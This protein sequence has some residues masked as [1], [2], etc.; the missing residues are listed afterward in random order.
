M[1]KG[2]IKRIVEE[3][4]IS[5]A[6]EQL[7]AILSKLEMNENQLVNIL[8]KESTRRIEIDKRRRENFL[9]GRRTLKEEAEYWSLKAGIVGSQNIIFSEEDKER[10][11][12][13]ETIIRV[14]DHIHASPMDAVFKRKI[15]K[16]EKD[17]FKLFGIQQIE[18]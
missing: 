8:L 16:I 2:K 15:A 3:A 7:P 5:K 13:K 1:S 18:K 6:E 14:F 12:M 9:E 11:V 10:Q 17:I 4:T